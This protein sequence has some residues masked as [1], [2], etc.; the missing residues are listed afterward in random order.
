MPAVA[1]N[2]ISVAANIAGVMSRQMVGE[3]P[4]M[5]EL[6]AV[7]ARI[8]RSDSAVLIT[9]ESGSGKELAAEVIHGAS[10]R[11]DGPFVALN[12]AALPGSLV[13]AELFGFNKGSFNGAVRSHAGVFER[14]NG[15]TLFLDEITEMSAEMQAC[16]LRVL[17]SRRVTR[18]G[19]GMETTIDVR[20]VTAAS[21]CPL[22]AFKAGRLRE[23]IYY[24][25]AVL[26]VQVPPLRDRGNDVQL[27]IDHFLE[28]LNQR[29]GMHKR[30]SPALRHQF[31]AHSWP[32]NVR[33]LANALERAYVLGEQEL[34]PVALELM[35]YPSATKTASI[36]PNDCSIPQPGTDG[37]SSLNWS[38]VANYLVSSN[39]D[40]GVRCWEVQEQGGQIRAIPK[41]QG[42]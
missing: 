7:I 20:I 31:Q 26:P 4:A 36:A 21:R 10:T 37:I 40:G 9:G 25:L 34:Q 28:I 22:Q 42:E 38:P 15:G 14:A 5:R 24:R 1:V 41:A 35:A 8:S 33:E 39:W 13:E 12:C 16:L 6:R 23:D 27:L 11:C 29:H 18:L 3:S 2:Q 19:G 30:V 32:G 17:E